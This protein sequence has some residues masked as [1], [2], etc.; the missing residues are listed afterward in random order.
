MWSRNHWRAIGDDGE[1]DHDLGKERQPDHP[2]KGDPDPFHGSAYAGLIQRDR[3][4]RQKRE[5]E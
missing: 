5:R 2:I 1:H 4:D 3:G